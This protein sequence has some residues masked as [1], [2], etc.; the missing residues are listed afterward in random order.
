MT[1]KNAGHSLLVGKE[2]RQ[3]VALKKL[4]LRPILHV[5]TV[6]TLALYNKDYTFLLF[7]IIILLL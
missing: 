6:N 1:V 3:T 7:I 4:K 5:A 2:T